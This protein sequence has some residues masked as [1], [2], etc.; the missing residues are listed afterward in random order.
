MR[1]LKPLLAA[2]LAFVAISVGLLATLAVALG[3]ALLLVARRF[4][5]RL[6]ASPARHAPPRPS[7]AGAGESIDVV[8]TE[9]PTERR[10]R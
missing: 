2:F 10:A 5:R 6:R 1:I 7:P 8:A 3:G 9:I 4:F